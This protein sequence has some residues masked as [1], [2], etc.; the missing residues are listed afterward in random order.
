M[1]VGY[2]RRLV[3][4]IVSACML[5]GLLA[6]CGSSSVNQASNNR[7]LACYA[8]PMQDA[9]HLLNRPIGRSVHPTECDYVGH[10]VLLSVLLGTGR[11]GVQWARQAWASVEKET[12]QVRG[13]PFE[14]PSIVT[15]DHTQALWASGKEF[16]AGR[17]ISIPGDYGI[18]IVL[19]GQVASPQAVA[20]RALAIAIRRMR[21]KA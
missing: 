4:L 17:L 16:G 12:A 18:M 5:S 6:A 9:Q 3:I 15:V 1:T 13:K 20:E 19:E 21:A 8:L 2:K 14:V 10:G 11:G 7:N